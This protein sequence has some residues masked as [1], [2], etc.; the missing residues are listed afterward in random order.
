M[1][2]KIFALVLT[3]L[4]SSGLAFSGGHGYKTEVVVDG[5]DHP[6]S[7]AFIS[8]THWL[9]TEL[10]GGLRVVVDG[11]LDPNPVSG[12]PQ[13]FFTGQG[14][15]S[16]VRLHPNFSDNKLIYLSFALSLIHI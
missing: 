14:G 16:E 6:W 10:S 1:K 12:V 11:Q 13:I 9:V 15:L 3:L 5:L 8:D 4:I 2:N 7:V